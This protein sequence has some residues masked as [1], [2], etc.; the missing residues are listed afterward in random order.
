MGRLSA[1]LEWRQDLGVYIVKGNKVYIFAD[2]VVHVLQIIENSLPHVLHQHQMV[3]IC[4]TDLPS[5]NTGPAPS[6]LADK[7]SLD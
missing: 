2:V 7:L 1:Y 5:K 6:M 4:H 3:F